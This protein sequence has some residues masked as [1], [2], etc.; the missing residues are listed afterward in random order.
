[1]AN[2]NKLY[3]ILS[4]Q[5]SGSTFLCESLSNLDKNYID[6]G[7]AL[8]TIKFYN[9]KLDPHP[10][11]PHHGALKDNLSEK[12]L[13]IDKI[14]T[15]ILPNAKAIFFKVFRGDLVNNDLN[16]LTDICLPKKFIILRRDLNDS[17]ESLSR[18]Y[19]SGDWTINRKSNPKGYTAKNFKAK[20]IPPFEVYCENI[21]SWFSEC[22]QHLTEKG[23]DFQ[24][25]SFDLL[26]SKNFDFNSLI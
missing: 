17:Y 18:A 24:E 22:I 8:K 12:N 4:A 5:R 11:V 25:L 26:T 1:M 2:F 14:V 7:E 21:D 16:L 23:E 15:D 9:K 3:I 20:P 10:L 19:S 13:G 6:L